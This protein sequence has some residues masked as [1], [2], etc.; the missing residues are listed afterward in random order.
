MCKQYIASAL[1]AYE[2]FKIGDLRLI[3]CVL[4]NASSALSDARAFVL[5][6]EEAARHARLTNFE[7]TVNQ[8]ALNHQHQV[9]PLQLTTGRR[10]TPPP[11]P[12]ASA[13]GGDDS[14][15]IKLATWV[16]QRRQVPAGMSITSPTS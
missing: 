16:Q 4:E 14:S 15:A 11:T 5:G 1:R 13:N 7:A 10:R 6:D 3:D 8:R 12:S 9:T 2:Q